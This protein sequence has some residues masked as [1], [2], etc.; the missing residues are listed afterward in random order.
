NESRSY[1]EKM[2]SFCRPSKMMDHVKRN[3]LKRKDPQAKIECCHP[4]CKSQGLVL[5][6]LQDFKG[7]V[8]TV[9]GI[10]FREPRF[11]R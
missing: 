3:H 4:T 7:H 5:K 9:H 11:V 8:Q 6:H 2:G 10:K 1:E